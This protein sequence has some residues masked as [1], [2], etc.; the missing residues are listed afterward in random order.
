MYLHAQ[1]VIY[2]FYKRQRLKSNGD[3]IADV[4]GK[5]I[6][7]RFIMPLF[8]VTQPF[9]LLI[10]QIFSLANYLLCAAYKV[11]IICQN[12]LII[13]KNKKRSKT[14]SKIFLGLGIC[15]FTTQIEIT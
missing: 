4:K 8:Q 11:L 6:K 3:V 10:L 15:A 12:L 14:L 1:C 9:M 2:A 5:S 7:M 13:E